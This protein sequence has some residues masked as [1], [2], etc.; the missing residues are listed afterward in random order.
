MARRLQ[1]LGH[2]VRIFASNAAYAALSPL[3]DPVYEIPGFVLVYEKNRV[4]IRKSARRNLQ[5]WG[6]KERAIRQIEE[7]LDG[8][9]PDLAITDFEPFLPMVARRHGIPFISL[10]HQH[11]IP[12]LKLNPPPRYWL[13]FALTLAAVHATHR[14]EKANLVTSFFKP[15]KPFARDYHYF[16]PILRDELLRVRPSNGDH[17]LVYQTSS[18]FTRLPE[19]LQK[20]PLTFHIYAFPRE[21]R[22]GNCV[23]KPRNH[24]DFIQDLA[25]CSWVVTN[26]G[27]TLISE[28]LYLGKPVLSIPVAGQFEQWI[29]AYFLEQ[30]GF[31]KSCRPDQLSAPL[32]NEFVTQLP[33]CRARLKDVDFHGN[34]A[35]L[36]KIL[37]FL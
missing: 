23:F 26:G 24:P 27:Y 7:S 2:E 15:P 17:V 30:L 36:E 1:A 11:V 32:I 9:K 37:T 16:G 5:I 35:V 12:G 18:S 10:D 6:E 29:N 21:G 33:A 19:I 3:I 25:S 20:V 13:Q 34:E 31:G 28:S 14:G 4:R 22:E 8:F